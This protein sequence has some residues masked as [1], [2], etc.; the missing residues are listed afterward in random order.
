MID[1]RTIAITLTS[2]ILLVVIVFPM[3]SM[4][5]YAAEKGF[6]V[7]I[8]ELISPASLFSLRFSIML[9]ASTALINMILGLIV[10]V[11]LT[12]YNFMGKSILNAIVDLPIAVPTAVTGFTLLLLY[13]PL[14]YVGSS[15]KRL[16]IDVMFAFPGILLA[17]IFVTFPFMVRTIQPVL[18]EFEKIYE[19]AAATLGA[20]SWQTFRHIIL[21]SIM[22]G[23]ISGSVLAFSRSL[24]EFGSTIMVSGNI[25][26]RTQTA[27]LY[28]F[29]KFNTGD[30]SAA[31]AMAIVLAMISFIMLLLITFMR[32]RV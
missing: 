19:E 27:P 24:G 18:T 20:S 15:L 5:G 10:A 23:I 16:G 7:F 12:R 29:S 26:M 3:T 8:K 22:P 28:I 31:C 9:A 2:L 13:G 17:H 1:R 32:K 21:P 25:A 11:S 14:G 30:F 6:K 4:F